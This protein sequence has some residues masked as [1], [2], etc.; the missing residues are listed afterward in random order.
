MLCMND[1]GNAQRSLTK[2]QF[3]FIIELLHFWE[4]SSVILLTYPI[5]DR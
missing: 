4:Y 5:V 1:L 2:Q 3:Q